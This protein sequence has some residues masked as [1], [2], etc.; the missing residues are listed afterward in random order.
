MFGTDDPVRRVL[1]I[2]DNTAIHDDFR[3]ILESDEGSAGLADAAAA[4]FGE[5]AA[6]DD[7]VRYLVTSASQ[8]EEGFALVT[9]SIEESE[10]FDLAFVDMRMPP[11]WDGLET[12]EHL[13]AADPL[14]Q[15]V[16]CTA[17]SDYTWSDLTERLGQRDNL[18]ILKK[19]FDTAEVSQLAAAL[20]EKRRLTQLA[21]AKMDLLARVVAVRTRELEEAQHESESLLSSIASILVGIDAH[22]RIKRWNQS[23]AQM[24]GIPAEDAIGRP[25]EGL[26]IDWQ[27]RDCIS[28][29]L[30][31]NQNEE[32]EQS[33]AEFCDQ[34]GVSHIV[35]FSCF[36]VAIGDQDGGLLLLGRD[37]TERRSLELQLL[38]A[39]KLESIGQLAAGVA[40]E[41]NTPMQYIGDN[42]D[43]LKTVFERL[44][45]FLENC[46]QLIQHAAESE[47]QPDLTAALGLQ[48][49]KLRLASLS[50]QVSEALDDSA[51]GVRHVSRIVR[52]MKEFSH[53][54]TAEKSPVDLNR[55]LETTV[56]V[57]KNEWKYVAKLEMDLDA[58]LGTV[59]GFPGELNQVFLNL[60]VN[61][62]HAIA[63]KA[64]G[65][66]YDGVISL[67]TRQQGGFAQVSIQD[68]GGG[69]PERIRDRVFD[70]FFT[71]KAV[72]KGTGQGLAIAHAV[73]AKQHGGRIWFNVE[74]GVGTTFFIELPFDIETAAEESDE[75]DR[76]VEAC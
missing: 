75:A 58:D 70:P 49:K 59:S 24:F 36:R 46:T 37:I 48:A 41:I 61:A 62:A 65:G 50:E 45:P 51:D 68:N 53:P 63:E 8:G 33:E 5:A 11:G 38:Q 20:S 27:D 14:L 31:P 18:L 10:P 52:A 69:I 56:T 35:G 32:G 30:I 25:F 40:H 12:I 73:I 22:G 42:I 21:S 7:T 1:V 39:R 19:P 17:Y 71:T 43:Y 4:F 67:A 72:G 23:A 60:I 34:G 26:P 76:L 15:V 54:G 74:N 16:I 3:K 9:K 64:G 55:A 6:S 13:W 28:S 47:F 66:E 2:D 44:H 57:A 29:L